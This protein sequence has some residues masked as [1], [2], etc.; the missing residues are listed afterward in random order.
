MTRWTMYIFYLIL[1]TFHFTLNNHE[2][3]HHRHIEY[4]VIRY[5][6]H[7]AWQFSWS[8]MVLVWENG[9]AESNPLMNTK[10]DYGERQRLT[11]LAHCWR[12]NKAGERT[13]ECRERQVPED[14]RCPL[15]KSNW[16]QHTSLPLNKLNHSLI[17]PFVRET[18]EKKM[19]QK[20]KEKKKLN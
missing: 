19:T 13:R 10:A 2:N 18:K 20:Q 16:R 1:H 3:I 9:W 7:T 6:C 4:R 11:G 5:R 15:S 12:R 8:H 14:K 17:C